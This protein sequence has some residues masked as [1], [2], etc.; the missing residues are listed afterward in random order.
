MVAV[1]RA[2]NTP[3]HVLSVNKSPIVHRSTDTVFGTV[4]VVSRTVFRRC[5]VPY[6]EGVTYRMWYHTVQY[7]STVYVVQYCTVL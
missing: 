2:S 5:H 3:P 1:G 7:C 4:Y 6:S